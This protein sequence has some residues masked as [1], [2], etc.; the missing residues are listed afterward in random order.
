MLN[1]KIKMMKNI[2]HTIKVLLIGSLI[3]P[4]VLGIIIVLSPIIIM[5][6]IVDLQ[7]KIF[8]HLDGEDEK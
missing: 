5:G 3:F 7:S 2:K 6:N 8:K 4:F 1:G